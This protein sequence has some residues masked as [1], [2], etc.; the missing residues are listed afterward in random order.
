MIGSFGRLTTH[1]RKSD[2]IS[3]W[4]VSLGDGLSVC[5]ILRPPDFDI[6]KIN[7]PQPLFL[8]F[9]FVPSDRDGKLELEILRRRR[10]EKNKRKGNEEKE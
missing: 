6:T 4:S 2:D 7:E 9:S 8:S 1:W 10:Q 3:S 5:Q